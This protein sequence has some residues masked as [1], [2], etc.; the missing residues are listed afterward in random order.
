MI[1]N[2]L[3]SL[4]SASL[5]LAACSG[6]QNSLPTLNTGSAD[7]V[8]EQNSQTTEQQSSPVIDD[9]L[10]NSP[11][12]GG[13]R[14]LIITAED[15]KGSD[16]NTKQV[17]TV[18]PK[19]NIT[20][21][22]GTVDY[23]LSYKFMN[24]LRT[25]LVDPAYKTPA[26]AAVKAA[27]ASYAA[28]VPAGF[29]ARLKAS[30][31]T[32]LNSVPPQP[33]LGPYTDPLWCPESA[34]PVTTTTQPLLSCVG[35][36]NADAYTL[37]ASESA[38]ATLLETYNYVSLP[39][40]MQENES[41]RESTTSHAAV[42]DTTRNIRW[43][44]TKTIRKEFYTKLD[45][46]LNSARNTGNY[47]NANGDYVFYAANLLNTSPTVVG[48]SNI[49][50]N[51]YNETVSPPTGSLYRVNVAVTSSGGTAPLATTGTPAPA[52]TL[53]ERTLLASLIAQGPYVPNVGLID[54]VTG[55]IVLR[56]IGIGFGFK[57]TLA[58]DGNAATSYELAVGYG[59]ANVNA[60][61]NVAAA[62]WAAYLTGTAA[63]DNTPN[64]KLPANTANLNGASAVMLAKLMIDTSTNYNSAISAMGS[65]ANYGT[66]ATGT[67]PAMQ[68]A[69]A[70]FNTR[71]LHMKA[72]K[73][74]ANNAPVAALGFPAAST[75]ASATTNFLTPTATTGTTP[76]VIAALSRGIGDPTG[77][78]GDT[79]SYYEFRDNFTAM[80][81][82]AGAAINIF[83]AL[84]EMFG[85]PSTNASGNL[86]GVFKLGKTG[87]ST[88][89]NRNLAAI[90]RFFHADNPTN[91]GYV[92]TDAAAENARVL[93]RALIVPVTRTVASTGTVSYTLN[94]TGTSYVVITATTPSVGNGDNS[95]TFYLT[96]PGYKPLE[97]SA[98]INISSTS[99]ALVTSLYNYTGTLI[100]VSG[101]GF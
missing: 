97:G 77:L 67:K 48:T 23:I 55:N 56:D 88:S 87:T 26:G 92:Y 54:A 76:P 31:A 70:L 35:N 10:V 36:P 39:D 59:T 95:L 58:V 1:K 14:S 84:Y 63:I 98:S 15:V 52:P 79:T 69:K 34:P 9:N 78:P 81:P 13:Y 68:L 73:A 24:K 41:V 22:I 18:A 29:F 32:A 57:D 2:K 100:G 3:T 94:P 83:D 46:Y 44:N 86:R 47:G 21:R 17:F 80:T 89:T 49:K 90:T 28:V 71:A 7:F 72:G 61:A 16:F 82:E 19:R 12:D 99:P 5:L 43:L 60:T 38:F 93:T 64:F 85:I 51:N 11:T 96:D 65:A 4:L 66:N 40:F 62:T 53:A 6:T 91:P 37:S 50:T 8:P 42:T 33:A 20:I 27:G 101:D 75:T 30:S 45:A 74:D 25:L